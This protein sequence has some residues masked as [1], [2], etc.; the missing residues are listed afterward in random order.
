MLINQNNTK[1]RKTGYNYKKLLLSVSNYE[2][3]NWN[4]LFLDNNISFNRLYINSSWRKI[5]ENEF[6]KK[7]FQEFE[8]Y[9]SILLNNNIK[10]FPHPNLVFNAFN[11]CTLDKIKVVIIGQDPYHGYI[12]NNKIIPQAV[13]LSFS[14]PIGMKIPSSLLNIYKNM[15]KYRI[16]DKIPDHGNL[17]FWA[18][19]GCLMLNSSLT[20]INNKPNSHQNYW[21]PFTDTIIKYISEKCNNLV[22]LL[23]GKHAYE[24]RKLIDNTKH[25]IIHSTHPS[26]LS[27]SKDA[28]YGKAFIKVNHFK[29][30]NDYLKSVNKNPII[31]RL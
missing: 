3:T 7:Y 22:F 13:G 19:Q 11:I 6:K 14:I 12:D 8:N 31:W 4:N 17:Y 18:S 29:E 16:I 30:C 21:T 25:K 1:I 15:I 24:K 20:V 9:M 27:F 10:I 28:K 5:F 26:G 23:W 2:Y